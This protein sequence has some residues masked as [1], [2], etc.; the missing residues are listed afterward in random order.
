MQCHRHRSQC[1]SVPFEAVGVPRVGPAEAPPLKCHTGCQLEW[2]SLLW[3]CCRNLNYDNCCGAGVQRA[4]TDRLQHTTCT[5]LHGAGYTP[6]HTY[7][8]MA[9]HTASHTA[10]DTPTGATCLTVL[11]VASHAIVWGGFAHL[12]ADDIMSCT[13]FSCWG[14]EAVGC[15]MVRVGSFEG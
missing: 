13:S 4:C 10:S 6:G 5:D 2:A 9:G 11:W 1:L 14:L 12:R 15:F 7:D 3:R 8:H